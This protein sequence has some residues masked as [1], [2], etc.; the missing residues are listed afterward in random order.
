[1]EST[2]SQSERSQKKRKRKQR[3]DVTN[4]KQIVG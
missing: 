3:A 2:N 1:M 4:R